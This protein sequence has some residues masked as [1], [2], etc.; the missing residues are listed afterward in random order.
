MG[1]KK[2]KTQYLWELLTP[3]STPQSMPSCNWWGLF[4]FLFYFKTKLDTGQTLVLR[5]QPVWQPRWLLLP[6][7]VIKTSAATDQVSKGRSLFE[8]T[9]L[10]TY[11]SLAF[12]NKPSPKRPSYQ[13]E[14]I[15]D[16][17]QLSPFTDPGWNP[18]CDLHQSHAVWSSTLEWIGVRGT[19]SHTCARI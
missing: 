18:L 5:G 10:V 13:N 15:P 16:C 14:C 3:S 6:P 4:L 9:C 1:K 12:G 11:I 8:L 2:N 7:T 19:T 17:S